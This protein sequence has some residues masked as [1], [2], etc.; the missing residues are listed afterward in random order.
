MCWPV[1]S[2]RQANISLEWP[3]SSMIGAARVLVRKDYNNAT[4]Q[5]VPPVSFSYTTHAFRRVWWLRTAAMRAPSFAL[6]LPVTANAEPSWRLEFDFCLLSTTW[7]EELKLSDAWRL[8]AGIM[9]ASFEVHNWLVVCL[10]EG[11]LL[12]ILV[13]RRL[14]EIPVGPMFARRSRANS[15]LTAYK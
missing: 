6:P 10:L 9:M 15:L 11:L 2:N 12:Q 8:I 7:L 13:G 14:K 5:P 4:C 1:G 3:V